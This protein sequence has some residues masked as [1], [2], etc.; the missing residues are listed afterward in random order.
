MS[1]LGSIA[2]IRMGA[3]L[4]GRDATRPVLNGRYQLLRIGDISPNGELRNTK[5]FD[6]IEPQES[7]SAALLLRKGDVLFPNRG[8]RNTAIVYDFDT[9]D[10]IVGPQFFILRPDTASVLPEYLAWY[11]RSERAGKYFDRKRKG[12]HVQMIQRSDLADMEVPL[13]PLSIQQRIANA[14]ELALAE[15]TLSEKLSVSKW[16][17]ANAQLLMAAHKLS[18]KRAQFKNHENSQPGRY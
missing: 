14:A 12:T 16:K 3:T 8:T 13:P 7:I 15:K 5:E 17:L 2:E 9:Q 10:V 4:R 1:Q 6:R 11:L 18:D